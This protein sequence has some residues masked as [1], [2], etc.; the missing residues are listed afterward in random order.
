VHK[1]QTVLLERYELKNKLLTLT[2]LVALALAA[3]SPTLLSVNAQTQATVIMLDSIG[4]TTTPAAGTTT[5]PDG[6]Q[7]TLSATAQDV[8]FNFGY[9]IIST[10][11]SSVTI[12]D[13]PV[14]IPVSAGT[15]YTIQAVFNP[16][17]APAGGSIPSN[18]AT[19]AIIVVLPSAGGTTSPAPGTYAID[20]AAN[21]N[22]T[23]MANSGWQFSHWTI[24]GT[25]TNH[26]GAPTNW[27]PTDNPYNVNHG[28]GYTYYYQAIF[29]P[30]GSSEPTPTPTQGT[31]GGIMGGIS[32]ETVIIIGLVIVIVVILAAFGVMMMKK[33]KHP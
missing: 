1:Q 32:T 31:T 20:N 14:T 8:S 15:T 24:C 4:G 18:L 21:V 7:V 11:T 12:T 13:N 17:Q 6:T 9:W 23:A 30:A 29:T 3:L 5:Y 26:G 16:I 27:A 25:N 19:A 22:L 2:L 10:D 28:Y 33:N